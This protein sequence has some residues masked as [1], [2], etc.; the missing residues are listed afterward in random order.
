MMTGWLVGDN[1]NEKALRPYLN[2]KDELSFHS[3]CLLW[4]SCGIIPPKECE[5]VMK[6][7]HESHPG[8]SRMKSL[9]RGNVWWPGLDQRLEEQ[10]RNCASCQHSGNKPPT[11]PFHRWEC[12][13]R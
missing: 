7:F 2:K 11:A 4:G 6:V 8:I 12:P 1:D 13:E 10:A 5:M 9:A 3:G